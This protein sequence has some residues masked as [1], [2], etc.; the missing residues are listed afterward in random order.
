[1]QGGQWRKRGND[2][3]EVLHEAGGAAGGG[4]KYLR[5][6][7]PTTALH[8]LASY[9]PEITPTVLAADSPLVTPLSETN[10]LPL[11][12]ILIAHLRQAGNNEQS[13]FEEF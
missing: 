13:D 6:R 9:T 2:R 7:T 3:T 1:M 11:V 8:C 12:L 10:L 5:K 4:E